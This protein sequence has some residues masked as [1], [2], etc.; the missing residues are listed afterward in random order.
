MFLAEMEAL[1]LLLWEGVTLPAKG[2]SEAD[3]TFEGIG[4]QN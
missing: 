3:R 1:R 4:T 2:L